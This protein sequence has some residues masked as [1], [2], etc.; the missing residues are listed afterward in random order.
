MRHLVVGVLGVTLGFCSLG[1][2][3]DD[4]CEPKER[5]VGNAAVVRAKA[6]ESAGDLKRALDLVA[7]GD[8]RAC[9]DGADAIY[10]RVLLALGRA[11]EAAGQSV[12]AFD[13]FQTGS[14]F[15][16][17]KRV[18]L[19]RFRAKPTDRRLADDILD[20][21]RRN[22]FADGVAEVQRVARSQAQRLLAEEDKSFAIREPHTELLEEAKA[23]L[24]T[25]GDESAA[26][27]KRRALARGDQFAALDYH[28]ALQQ[29]LTYYGRADRQ[30]K[31]VEV[32][33]KARQVADKLAGGDGWNAAVELYY[34]AGDAKRAEA[35]QASR[36]ASAAK[37]EDSRKDR[38]QKEQGDLEKQL[39]L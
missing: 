8:V 30:D 5:Q 35:L 7:S 10:M 17:A 20:F 23:W 34:L 11:A 36:S 22:D 26:D 33:A 2:R 37:Q 9:G 38:F 3:A 19:A 21:M 25:A 6:A 12:Q 15:D 39:G 4:T 1:V 32:K 31:Q 13:Y 24:G 18:G 27:V 16:D 29:A 14:Y 28:Y